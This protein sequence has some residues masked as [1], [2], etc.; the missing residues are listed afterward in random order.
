MNG[1][2]LALV[3]LPVLGGSMPIRQAPALSS[4]RTAPMTLPAPLR[5]G[6]GRDSSRRQV[7]PLQVTYVANEGFLIAM[8]DAKVLIDALHE[9]PWGYT[10]TP[11]EVRAMMAGGIPPFDGVDL[12]IASHPH[13][14]H[15]TPSLI[16]S[17]LKSR[18]RVAF[19]GSNATL[20]MLRDSTGV[21]F[22]EIEEQVRE[23][24]PEWGE[25]VGLEFPDGIQARFL[26]LNHQTPD[27]DPF[28]TLGSLV[29]LQGRTILHL[30]DLFPGTSVPLLEKYDWSGT[31][32][33]V[34]FAD[35]YFVTSEEGKR[36]IGEVIKPTHLV[37]MHLRPQDWAEY[38]E[39]VR[40]FWP[41]VVVFEEPLETRAF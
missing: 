29:T 28:L 5:E 10:N 36:L 23:V 31:E 3:L 33:D 32:V 27:R 39:E 16:H 11:E 38:E 35:P 30:A 34:L 25:S 40:A 21:T 9:N 7:P 12:F 26:T 6:G 17:Y 22:G 4:I 2:L 18:Q 1:F 8:G 24:S 41:Q 15:F 14:D 20:G 37:M 13:A 19:V